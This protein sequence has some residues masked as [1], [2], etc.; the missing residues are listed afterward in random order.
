[1][2]KRR[3]DSL[4]LLIPC[5]FCVTLSSR[6]LNNVLSANAQDVPFHPRLDGIEHKSKKRS[7]T[8]P[9]SNSEIKEIYSFDRFSGSLKQVCD[10]L[11]SDGRKTRV[12]EMAR[13]RLRDPSLT[14]SYRA[15]VKEVVLRCKPRLDVPSDQSPRETPE[16]ESTPKPAARYPSTAL[17]D[18]VSALSSLMYERDAG[19]GPVFLAT[20]EL[21]DNLRKETLNIPAERDYFAIFNE[22]L[23]SAWQGRPEAPL[24]PTQPSQTDIH[25]LFQ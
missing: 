22:Y 11:E 14:K 2:R 16:A 1:M 21:A 4:V 17:L 19:I 10:L 7:E 25:S 6:R 23:L 12:Y 9:I 5:L 24:E 20:R 3:V 13:D 18:R 15:L 8:T